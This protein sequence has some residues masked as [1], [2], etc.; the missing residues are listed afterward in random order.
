MQQIYPNQIDAYNK[1]A[2]GFERH[3]YVSLIAQMQSGKSDTFFLVAFESLRKKRVERV[4]IFTGNS[5]LVLKRQTLDGIKHFSRKYIDYLREKHGIKEAE[6]AGAYKSA[7]SAIQV[8]WSSQLDET[9]DSGFAS[10]TLFIWEESHYA[11]SKTML[12]FTFLQNRLLPPSGGDKNLAENGNFI[13]S[14]S[15]TPFS[16]FAATITKKQD[17]VV[18]YLNPGE[19]YLGVE[20]FLKRKIIEPHHG[21]DNDFDMALRSCTARFPGKPVYGIVRVLEATQ[22]RFRQIAA[23]NHW[24]YKFYNMKRREIDIHLHQ[25]PERNTIVFIKGA[26]RMG[27]QVCKEHVGFCYEAHEV[28]NTDTILQGLVG[29]M[30]SFCPG[31]MVDKIRI[32]VHEAN[33]DSGEIQRYAKF[34]DALAKGKLVLST[35]PQKAMNVEIVKRGSRAAARTNSGVFIPTTPLHIPA[36]ILADDD[37]DEDEEERGR[38][39]SKNTNKYLMSRICAVLNDVGQH[40]GLTIDA[41]M[42]RHI[43]ERIAE[44]IVIHN[45]SCSSHQ[46]NVRKMVDA[47]QRGENFRSSM[48][49]EAV[50]LW[51]VDK[52]LPDFPGFLVGDVIIEMSMKKGEG[53]GNGESE[54]APHIVC[55]KEDASFIHSLLSGTRELQRSMISGAAAGTPE[56]LTVDKMDNQKRKLLEIYLNK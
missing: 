11:Q 10:N 56:D 26:L 42:A 3:R 15:A 36:S 24:D 38:R 1:I 30:C 32:Y 53:E 12:P 48:K 50:H 19:K 20:Y 55:V 46:R 23:A 14:V 29:R 52:A 31:D 4:I 13:L 37:D 17:K 39:K 35:M 45:W 6:A 18:V 21:S 22:F 25:A 8:V 28:G 43:E 27:Q 47:M 16:E 41:E 44:K 9:E 2:A 7:K 5:D 54:D 33:F 34:I 40:P 49:A 51:V